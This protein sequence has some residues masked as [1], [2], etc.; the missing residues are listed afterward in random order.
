MKKK[1]LAALCAICTCATS[2]TAVFIPTAS[3]KTYTGKYIT[4]QDPYTNKDNNT[5]TYTDSV[6][7]NVK[8]QN[9]HSAYVYLRYRYHLTLPDETTTAEVIQDN[10]DVLKL[11]T[12]KSGTTSITIQVPAQVYGEYTLHLSYESTPTPSDPSSF[13]QTDFDAV[14]FTITPPMV[15]YGE[16]TTGKE[17]DTF[18]ESDD[19]IFHITGTNDKGRK[20]YAKY[21]Y[22]VK[23]S[24][25]SV[26][27]EY[28]Q[29]NYAGLNAGQQVTRDIPIENWPSGRYGTFTL[30]YTED[31]GPSTTVTAP[32]EFTATFTFVQL[33]ADLT[34]GDL[35]TANPGNIFYGTEEIKFRMPVTNNN[36]TT[37]YGRYSY[38]VKNESGTVVESGSEENM[39][40][41]SGNS[42]IVQAITLPVKE[43]KYGFYTIEVTEYS[44]AKSSGAPVTEKKFTDEFSICIALSNG[45]VDDSFGFNQAIVNKGNTAG[46]QLIRKAGGSWHR[47]DISWVGVESTPGTFNK[48]G[49]YATT[50]SDMRE[51]GG[52]NTVAI[53][54]GRH[55]SYCE[56]Y[57][58][59]TTG[60]ELTKVPYVD[61]QG[62]DHGFDR[63]VQFCAHVADQLKG[64]VDHYEIWNEWNHKNFNPSGESAQ[65]YAKLLKAASEAIKAV[66]PDAKIIGC[67]TSGLP[68]TWYHDFFYANIGYD[69]NGNRLYIADYMDAV[70]F[71]A[72]DFNG[73]SDSPTGFPE[74]DFILKLQK[75]R[76]ALGKTRSDGGYQFVEKDDNGNYTTKVKPIWITEVGFSTYT[77]SQGSFFV[78]GCTEQDQLNSMVLFNTVNKTYG[79][80]DKV[81]QYQLNDR[82][83]T[84]KQNN[85][86]YK[87]HN[88]NTIEQNWGVLRSWEAQY[89]RDS[90]NTENHGTE[91]LKNSAKPA[92]LGLAAMNYFIGGNTVALQADEI[93]DTTNRTY[94]FKFK[95]NN[96]NKY[97]WVAIRG[98]IG[99][100]SDTKTL[101]IGSPKIDIYDKYGNFI[102]TRESSTGKYNLEIRPEPIYIVSGPKLIVEKSG[103]M[104]TSGSQIRGGD[105]LNVSLVGYDDPIMSAATRPVVVA[106]Q[107]DADNRFLGCNSFTRTT[108]FAGTITVASSARSIKVLCW[109]QDGYKPIFDCVEIK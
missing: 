75:F 13:V 81:I 89:N 31:S 41:L 23:D 9:N 57:T 108:N 4:Y 28:E 11:Q 45:N 58:D 48:L 88:N 21:S 6:V 99:V 51:K 62:N 67:A 52:V 78:P 109:D 61:S 38:V 72:Y 84:E 92:Y 102:Q 104:V 95:N 33:S 44:S 66:D 60:V 76:T 27:C 87:V 43:R 105:T 46:T 107:Y 82:C 85:V 22:V 53:L 19:I 12:G 29:E 14:K 69:T 15:T 8:A 39:K 2:F 47:E 93:K 24:S 77:G 79:L 74:Q 3:A 32:Q 64:A 42:N 103:T 16:L 5:F 70:S 106:A 91:V 63:Y 97:V 101:D 30:Y 83:G 59:P 25:N 10:K 71:H 96:L 49:T 86:T 54:N 50:L 7:F 26:V 1:I 55:K 98:G 73:T 56:S 36:A 68:D 35:Y 90:V 94:A 40:P 17:N 37:V 20:L 80:I 100:G 18:L 65:D 34:Y